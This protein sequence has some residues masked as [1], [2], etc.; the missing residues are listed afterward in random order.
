MAIS[1]AKLSSRVFA[2]IASKNK[3]AREGFKDVKSIITGKGGINN[4]E[5]VQ[6]VRS[7]G[8]ELLHPSTGVNNNNPKQVGN[9]KKKHNVPGGGLFRR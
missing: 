6:Q 9:P 8:S 7:F 2:K 4:H 5:I 1:G 3:D